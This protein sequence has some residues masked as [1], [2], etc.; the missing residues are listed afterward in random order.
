VKNAPRIK[1][2]I[3]ILRIEEVKLYEEQKESFLH[4]GQ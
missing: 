3:L 4:D 2:V 1:V